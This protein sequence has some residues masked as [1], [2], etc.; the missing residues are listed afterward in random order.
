[1]QDWQF[2]LIDQAQDLPSVR[3]RETFWQHKL[4]T[5]TPL[6]LNERN[7]ALDYG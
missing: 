7:V 6:G 2:T 1:M 4:D 3:R 5:F